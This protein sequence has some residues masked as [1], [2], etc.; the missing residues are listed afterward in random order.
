MAE[1]KAKLSERMT[2]TLSNE[3]AK[4]LRQEK[5]EKVKHTLLLILLVVFGGILL[6]EVI[7]PKIF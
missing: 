2:E 5:I 4:R 3:D 6:I 7:L 1:K